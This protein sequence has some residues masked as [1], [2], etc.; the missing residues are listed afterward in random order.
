MG[1]KVKSS[2]ILFDVHCPTLMVRKARK[3]SR[4]LAETDF[5]EYA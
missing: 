5:V 3:W 4:A 2:I 1:R